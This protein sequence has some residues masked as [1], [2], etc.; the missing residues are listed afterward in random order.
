MHN[1][2]SLIIIFSLLTAI[3]SRNYLSR[4]EDIMPET[5][6]EEQASRLAQNNVSETNVINMLVKM[7]STE[8]YVNNYIPLHFYYNK[9]IVKYLLTRNIYSFYLRGN[10]KKDKELALLIVKKWGRAAFLHLDVNMQCD[11]EVVN[12]AFNGP[13]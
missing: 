13:R 1:Y 7:Q 10:L 11:Y 12:A 3:Q 6:L 4:G 8:P 2:L 5:Y 9:N